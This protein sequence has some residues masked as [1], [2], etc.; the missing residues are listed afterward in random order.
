MINIKQKRLI[1][2]LACALTASSA[3]HAETYNY[4]IGSTYYHWTQAVDWVDGVLPDADDAWVQLDGPAITNDYLQINFTSGS[5]SNKE[6]SVSAISLQSGFN[7]TTSAGVFSIKN[8]SSSGSRRGTMKF[9]GQATTI[10]GQSV[11]ALIEN[12]TENVEFEFAATGD[13]YDIELQTSGVIYGAANTTTSIYNP[14]TAATGVTPTVTKM[15]A[16]TLGLYNASNDLALLDLQAGTTEVAASESGVRSS[17]TGD[18][19]VADGATLF[20]NADV[21]GVVTVATGAVLNPFVSDA[22]EAAYLSTETLTMA[23]GSELAFTFDSADFANIVLTDEV[24]AAASS[25]DGAILSIELAYDLMLG[26]EF[27][28]IENLGDSSISG[29]FSYDGSVLADG[30]TFS[31]T[32]GIYSEVFEIDYA[33][34][35]GDSIALVVIPEIS[36]WALIGGS[37]ALAFVVGSRRRKA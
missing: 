36:S 2:A 28:I 17:I 31:V 3:A 8:W 5:L 10:E 27:V 15:G 11:T 32:T 23:S 12:Y 18:V 30:D 22:S 13:G 20:A 37:M 33:Y 25:I 14:I 35:A 21:G 7:P 9:Y 4:D 26:D 19:Q 6:V 24:G 34:G 16:G 1:G 29:L